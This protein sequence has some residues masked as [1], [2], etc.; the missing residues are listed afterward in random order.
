MF[1]VDQIEIVPT[2]PNGVIHMT[3]YWD[4]AGTSK[5][6]AKGKGAHTAGVKMGYVSQG[7]NKGKF[8]ILDSVRG[9]WGSSARE[10]VIRNTAAADG[11]PT[12]IW[13]EQEPGSGGKES[14]ENTVRN[15]A[16]YKIKTECPSGDKV[17]RA[18]P[19]SDQVAVGNVIVLKGLWNKEYLDE[20]R[21]FP[22][23]RKDQIDGSS[24]AFNKMPK[25]KG[26]Y[27]W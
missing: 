13:V 22:A 12:T 20:M 11:K 25:D 6:K 17:V 1:D 18:E 21:S 24:G 16:G 15:L 19:L 5:L 3:R 23:G 27:T 2:L 9:Q 7:P 4:K 8:I 10:Q 26:G 14:A